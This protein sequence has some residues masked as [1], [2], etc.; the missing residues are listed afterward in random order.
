M[1]TYISVPSLDFF[2]RVLHGNPYVDDEDAPPPPSPSLLS[3]DGTAS[4]SSSSS[5]SLVSSDASTP[6][7]DSRFDTVSTSPIRVFVSQDDVRVTRRKARV[8][9]SACTR[10]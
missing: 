8:S 9:F 1:G 5:S 10:G 3:D 2:L 4:S 6:P 7:S